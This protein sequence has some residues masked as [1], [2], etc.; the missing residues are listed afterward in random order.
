MSYS[1]LLAGCRIEADVADE[2]LGQLWIDARA[3][4]LRR[5][6]DDGAKLGFVHGPEADLVLLGRLAQTVMVLDVGIE[7]RARA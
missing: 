3:E 6:F 1:S 7:V 4:G 2:L 5:P